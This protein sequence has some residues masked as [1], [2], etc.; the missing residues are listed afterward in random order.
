MPTPNACSGYSTHVH[1]WLGHP[2]PYP[3]PQGGRVLIPMA[4]PRFTSPSTGE[5][6]AQRRVGVTH[7]FTTAGSRL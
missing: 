7:G 5:V 2:P 1:R 4:P 3:P 6:G